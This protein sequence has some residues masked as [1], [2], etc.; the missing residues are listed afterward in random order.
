MSERQPMILDVKKAGAPSAD[1]KRQ[2]VLESAMA[3]VLRYGFQ[4]ATMDDVAKEAGMSRPALYLLFKNKTGVYQAL[5]EQ[6][7]SRALDASR[8]ALQGGGAIETR[9][10]QAVKAGILDPTDF[11]M[12][13]AH[14]AELLDMKHKMAAEAL[15]A[16]RT[17]TAAMIAAALESSGAAKS[18]G[19]SGAA[20]ADILLDGMEG[21]KLRA[22]TSAEREAG[23]KALVRLVAGKG[24]S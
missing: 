3:V 11:L 16:W 14:G 5:A 22:R 18:K 6:M 9:V 4:R 13:T 19:M 17:Q 7:M 10:F 24:A 2:R 23:A 15:Q 21:L 1:A 20:L 8:A 12:A